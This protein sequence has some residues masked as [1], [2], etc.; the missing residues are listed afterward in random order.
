[1]KRRHTTCLLAAV[2]FLALPA[3]AGTELPSWQPVRPE[4]R[5]AALRYSV[6]FYTTDAETLRKVGDLDWSVIGV[7]TDPAKLPKAFT[8][9]AAAVQQNADLTMKTLIEGSKLRKCDFEVA[10]EQGW[11]VLLPHLGKLRQCSRLLRVDARRL[12]VE[13]DAGTAA[14]R[15]ATMI[16]IAAHVRNDR[17]LIGSLVG[18]AILY[19]AGAEIDALIDSGRLTVHAR[20]VLLEPLRALDPTDPV[21]I[22]DALFGEKQITTRWIVEN[23]HGPRAGADLVATGFFDAMGAAQDSSPPPATAPPGAATVPPSAPKPAAPRVAPPSVTP[24]P[25][26]HKAV[27]SALDEEHLRGEVDRIS[28]F[29]DEALSVW[30]RADADEKLKAISARVDTGEFGSLIDFA[31]AITKAHESTVKS[32]REVARLIFRLTST[33]A[34]P[35]PSGV[36]P[37]P[38]K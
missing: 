35:D 9:A 22:R 14:E 23:F 5:N 2:A 12:L 30:N 19:Q 17:L 7:E 24:N 37:S 6:A 4:D 32:V 1:M 8:D 3:F 13:G 27:V 25:P 36:A 18:A 10:Y 31:P 29:Y 34:H 26:S 15:V 28:A 20:D 38:A 16:R 11:M 21:S 33:N